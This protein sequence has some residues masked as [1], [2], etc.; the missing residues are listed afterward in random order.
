MLSEYGFAEGLSATNNNG[1]YQIQVEID[2]N[3]IRGVGN[4]GFG[5]RTWAVDNGCWGLGQ[6]TNI[7]IGPPPAFPDLFVSPTTPNLSPIPDAPSNPLGVSIYVSPAYVEARSDLR[8]L[9]WWPFDKNVESLTSTR[10][11]LQKGS[12]NDPLIAAVI[13]TS[14]SDATLA[15]SGPNC[16]LCR[17]TLTLFIYLVS[18]PSLETTKS[19]ASVITQSG[20]IARL[21]RIPF[22]AKTLNRIQ[23]NPLVINW[24]HIFGWRTLVFKIAIQLVL[25]GCI[26]TAVM[27]KSKRLKL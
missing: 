20:I 25:S 14:S 27:W 11:R 7:V 9:W 17:G 24:L 4:A 23:S 3:R 8:E 2:G 6:F 15:T 21:A 16:P 10:S 22:I 5:R 1:T 13:S 12:S 26:S 18:S 19:P